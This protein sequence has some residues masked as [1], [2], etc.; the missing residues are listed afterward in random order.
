MAKQ[1]SR[2][3]IYLES[4]VP[5]FPQPIEQDIRTFSLLKVVEGVG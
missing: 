2:L 5:F 3:Q 4:P 1:Q